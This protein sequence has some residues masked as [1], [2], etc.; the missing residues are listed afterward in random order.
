MSCFHLWLDGR[1]FLSMIDTGN[2][3]FRS[4]RNLHQN[5]ALG[6][7]GRR[8]LSWACR[9]WRCITVLLDLGSSKVDMPSVSC[10]SSLPYIS[11][12]CDELK[13]TVTGRSF[14]NVLWA[15]A[16]FIRGT[17]GNVFY[18]LPPILPNSR[19]S[20]LCAA[21]LARPYSWGGTTLQFMSFC[22]LNDHW[23]ISWCQSGVPEIMNSL[24]VFSSLQHH[25]LRTVLLRGT[26]DTRIMF[27]VTFLLQNTVPY[28]S[29]L[30]T[31]V[32]NSEI[33]LASAMTLE[34]ISPATRALMLSAVCH[35]LSSYSWLLTESSA[36]SSIQQL[37]LCWASSPCGKQ[38]PSIDLRLDAYLGSL[39][40]SRLVRS[41]L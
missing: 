41:S 16:F 31:N 4:V 13:H 34:Y 3:L 9:S 1:L 28:H 15:V 17:N 10:E 26:A 7:L 8:V 40:V 30:S 12:L 35:V 11:T 18:V 29:V 23:S 2:H 24:A 38:W 36:Y 6:V 22:Q 21:S 14:E 32:V 27:C 33:R 39:N 19:L 25:I 5:T 20:A 37:A